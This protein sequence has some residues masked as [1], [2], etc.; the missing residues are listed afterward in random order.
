MAEE[1]LALAINLGARDPCRIVAAARK[2]QHPSQAVQLLGRLGL[3]IAVEFHIN[4]DL[5]LFVERRQRGKRRRLLALVTQN[6]QG[7]SIEVLDGGRMGQDGAHGIGKGHGLVFAIEKAAHTPNDR[8]CRLQGNLELGD[9][10]ERAASADKEV[11]GVH[12]V[13]NEIA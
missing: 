5:G 4:T 6:I 12:I 8:R 9:N 11:D 13:R 7:A 3:V 1:P 2:L 10:A